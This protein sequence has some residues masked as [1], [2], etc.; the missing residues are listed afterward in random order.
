MLLLAL[1]RSFSHSYYSLLM[2][3]HKRILPMAVGSIALLSLFG[4]GSAA[5]ADPSQLRPGIALASLRLLPGSL[6][7]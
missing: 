5:L 7:L 1:C 2:E 3:K 4:L 6:I